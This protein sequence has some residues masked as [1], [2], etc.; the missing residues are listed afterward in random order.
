MIFM[1]AKT[2]KF[3]KTALITL[4]VCVL[5]IV[6]AILISAFLHCIE[7]RFGI[8]VMLGIAVIALFTFVFLLVRKN[9]CADNGKQVKD[10]FYRQ[11]GVDESKFVP[12]GDLNY[13]VGA[14]IYEDENGKVE[15]SYTD[16]MPRKE[17]LYQGYNDISKEE[18]FANMADTKERMKM[19]IALIDK[20]IAGEIK[21]FYYWDETSLYIEDDEEYDKE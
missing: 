18:L 8:W 9:E 7:M 4:I 17:R 12:F 20:F 6:C 11:C 1:K 16:Y 19:A 15:I 2:K 3:F 21:H 10:M 5:G 14:D 13:I